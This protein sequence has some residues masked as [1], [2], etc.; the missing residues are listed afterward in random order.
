MQRKILENNFHL[1]YSYLCTL[2]A[3]LVYNFLLVTH[4]KDASFYHV[5][6]S[7]NDTILG[8]ET[9]SLPLIRY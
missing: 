8:I 3:P 7:I 9:A 2:A 6:G 4:S 5:M 1:F